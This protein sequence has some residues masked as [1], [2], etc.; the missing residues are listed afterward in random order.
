[1]TKLRNISKFDLD[2]ESNIVFQ[3]GD[4]N[5]FIKLCS[6]G[7]IYVK[8]KLIENDKELVDGL[9]EWLGRMKND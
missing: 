8:G 5:E 2:S 6:N 1:M 9:R 3:V 4:T 7:D